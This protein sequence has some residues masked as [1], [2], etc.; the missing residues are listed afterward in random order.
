MSDVEPDLPRRTS[1][2]KV[3]GHFHITTATILVSAKGGV[4]KFREPGN[5]AVWEVKVGQMFLTQFT[6][7]VWPDPKRY[8]W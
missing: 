5:N 3:G 2:A 4:A 8:D 1:S 7:D 6:A